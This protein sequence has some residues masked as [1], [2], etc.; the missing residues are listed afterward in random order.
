MEPR[1]FR[2]FFGLA[3]IGAALAASVGLAGCRVNVDKDAN[4][5]EKK[6]QVDTPFGGVHVNT[7]QTSAADLGLPLYPGAEP[8]TDDDKHKSADVHLGFGEWQLRV[9]AVSYS[10]PDSQEKVAAFYKKALT[11]FGDV[12]TCHG[13]SPIGTPTVTHEGLTCSDNGK[14]SKVK[15]DDNDFRQDFQLK[16]GSKRHQ[17]IVGFEDAKAGK[18]RFALVALDLPA[19]LDND[20]DK[21][22]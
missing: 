20:D 10:T 21:Q 9:K 13:N 1:N 12:I 3:A 5:K 18:T 7:D 22:Q 14:N 16:A 19:N 4:G 15:F 11:R 17:H 8:V 6:V 2:K